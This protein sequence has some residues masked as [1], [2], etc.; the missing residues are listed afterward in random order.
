MSKLRGNNSTWPY[1][2]PSRIRFYWCRLRVFLATLAGYI[3]VARNVAY[4]YSKV[5]TLEALRLKL[6]GDF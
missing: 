1:C 4:Q 3:S 5:I 2:L 6:A